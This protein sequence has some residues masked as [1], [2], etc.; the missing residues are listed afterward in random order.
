MACAVPGPWQKWEGE[1]RFAW[2]GGCRDVLERPHA[3][4][5]GGGT[6]LWTPLPPSSSPFN[7]ADSKN[8]T[9]APSVPR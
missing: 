5:G 2:G 7:E 9:S 8:F 3:A 1:K 4:G 6:P